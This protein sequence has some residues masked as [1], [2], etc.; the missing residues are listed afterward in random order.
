MPFVF[1]TPVMFPTIGPIGGLAMTRDLAI[2]D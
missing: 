1:S 2:A